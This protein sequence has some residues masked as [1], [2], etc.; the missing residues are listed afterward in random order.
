MKH[1]ILAFILFFSSQAYTQVN[2]QQPDFLVKPYLQ[3]G[4]NPSPKSMQLLWHAAVSNDVWLAEYKNSDETEWKRSEAQTFSTVAV[5][6]IAPF[7]VYSTSL[8]SLKPGTTFQYRVSK[9][10]K[11][12]FTSEAKSL[13]SE[14]QSYRIAISGDMGAGTGTSKKIA[15]EIYNA[16]PD[17]VAIAGDIVY[18]RGLVS[19]YKTKFWPVYNK[20]E[21]DTLG[22]PLMRSI[23][24]MASV[25]NHDALTRDLNGFPDALAY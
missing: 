7:N 23:P 8:T 4:K 13:K 14:E 10:A 6:S 24:F 5:G 9:N 17:M 16:K 12:V 18:N 20:D 3:I 19:E 15:F 11:V 21:A 1:C 25:G 22:A 2:N